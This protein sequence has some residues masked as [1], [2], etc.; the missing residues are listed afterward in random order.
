MKNPL[1]VGLIKGKAVFSF[2]KTS[3]R[4]QKIRY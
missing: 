3:R 2:K 4:K 1:T